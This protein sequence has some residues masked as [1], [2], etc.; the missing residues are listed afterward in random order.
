M[1]KI[2][3]FM[4]AAV[5]ALTAS[6]KEYTDQL[7]ITLNGSAPIVSEAKITVTPVE[8]KEN[9]YDIVLND[10]NFSGMPIGD[11]TI[12]GVTGTTTSTAGGYT[13]FNEVKEQEA[14]ITGESPIAAMLGNKVNVSIKPG[15]WMN[16]NELHMVINLPV[17]I[18]QLGQDFDVVAMFG[19]HGYQIPNSGFEE[20]HT[21]TA[22][23]IS[24][25]T[26]KPTESSSD[27][28]NS[29]HSFMS[30]TGDM[31]GFVCGTPQTYISD[32]VRP[33]SKGTKSVK[34]ISALAMGAIPANGTI[35][36]GQMQAASADATSTD[37]CAF[38]D[39][40]NDAVDGNGDPFYTVMTGTPDAIS[41]WV[42]FKQ[43]TIKVPEDANPDDYKYATAS[44]IITNGTRCQDPAP[45][46]ASTSNIVA[47]AQNAKI[48]SNNA[49]WQK[50]VIPFDYDT[51]AANDITA[52]A[53]LVTISTNALPGVGSSDAANPDEMY[54]DDIELVY[55][56]GLS[57]LAY[58][59]TEISLEEGKYEYNVEDLAA[60]EV[61][62][63]Q[64]EAVSDGRG[65]YVATDVT[66]APNGYKA[67]IIVNS[68]DFKTTN[69]YT[70]YI[71]IVSTGINEVETAEDNAAEAIYT[72]G[73]QRVNELQKGVNIVR[74][75]DGTTV[76]VLKK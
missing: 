49:E 9:T 61:T 43:G 69:T 33:E 41:M 63:D 67:N 46:D 25:P 68:N 13:F 73:G 21:E 50:V 27:E 17:V 36:T 65:A 20:F 45:A 5:I 53:I 26:F 34:L 71:N 12:T 54:V 8:G 76:K 3:T 59:G 23:A 31:K 37:N 32:D 22:T 42:K 40:M 14:T 16:E 44:A 51:Y 1:K 2:F 24:F 75:A 62:A 39:F 56:A 72:I 35:T 18:P 11:V 38:L 10:F 48:E 70:L 66:K 28:P 74:K 19:S 52:K 7:A 57:K 15:S 4:A 30:A 47:K 6:A 29:W 55:N 60:K 64:I 58:N